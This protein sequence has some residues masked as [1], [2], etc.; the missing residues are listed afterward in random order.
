VSGQE[1][2]LIVRRILVALDALPDHLCALEAA[3]ELAARFE[4]ELQGLFVEDTDLLRLVGTPF[5]GEVR[6]FPPTARRPDIQEMERHLRAQA[7]CMQRAFTRVAERTQ[8]RGSFRV[9]RGR[10]APEVLTA[11][12]QADIL[13]VGKAGWSLARS[14]RLSSTTRTLLSNTP[15]SML[16]LQAGA[17]LGRP[18]LVIYDGSPLAEKAL[19]AAADLADEDGGR[20][21]VL[22]VS[23]DPEEVYRLQ[24]QVADWLQGRNLAL[25]YRLSVRPDGT[26][27]ARMV[28]AERVGTLV[29]PAQSPVFHGE[30]LLTLLDEIS[31]PVL[32][33][34]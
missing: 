20:L 4:A 5:A 16:V 19:A 22:L 32:L 28:Q 14:S 27:L 34:R 15:A 3:A 33:V 9:A 29:L 11:A 1:R 13:I 31:V 8:V 10:I 23:D 30:A 24:S 25:R 18:V 12:S 26:K 17:R 2:N 7:A 21:T 6:R